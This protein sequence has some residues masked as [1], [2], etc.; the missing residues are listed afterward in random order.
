M[1]RKRRTYPDLKT[2]RKELGLSQQ[3]AANELGLTQSVYSRIERQVRAP[4]PQAAKAISEKSGVPLES[5]L[6]IA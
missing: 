4:K 2:R 5:I 1:N 3:Q 6:G